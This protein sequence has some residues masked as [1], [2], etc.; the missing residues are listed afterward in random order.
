MAQNHNLV[1][2]FSGENLKWINQANVSE[3]TIVSTLKPTKF[4]FSWEKKQ[5][6]KNPEELS[7][8]LFNLD[9]VIWLLKVKECI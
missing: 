5:T 3:S 1:P 6:T 4:I 2:K 9:H 8:K 7:M